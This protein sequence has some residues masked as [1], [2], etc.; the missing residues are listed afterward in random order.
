MRKHT[1]TPLH[2]QETNL[3]EH[4]LWRDLKEGSIHAFETI[5]KTYVQLVYNYGRKITNN[6]E[7]IH[8]CIQDLFTDIWKS[9]ENL[10]N[11]V[12]IRYYLYAS[13]KRRIILK[14]QQRAR[15]FVDE[16]IHQKFFKDTVPSHEYELIG[17]EGWHEQERSLQA[18]LKALNKTQ[19]EAIMLKFYKGL[20]YQEIAVKMSL[21]IANVYKIISRGL[22]VMEQHT[23]KAT[24]L[25][26][27]SLFS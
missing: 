19:R 25:L 9:R 15:Y 7:L 14:K 12:S 18:G 1:N 21:N 8:D 22:K 24:L 6:E 5:Y 10:G 2:K 26:L 16:P 20:S 11:I 23:H 4:I 17:Q 13:I 27:F 3:E